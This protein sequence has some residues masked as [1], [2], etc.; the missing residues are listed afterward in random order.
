[1]IGLYVLLGGISLIGMT[2]AALDYRTRRHDR[3]TGRRPAKH[4]S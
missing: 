3:R 1:M 4:T 2:I